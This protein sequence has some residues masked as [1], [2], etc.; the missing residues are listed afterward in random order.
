M[1]IALAPNGNGQASAAKD[2]SAISDEQPWLS[3]QLHSYDTYAHPHP[4]A[5]KALNDFTISPLKFDD[6]KSVLSSLTPGSFTYSNHVSLIDTVQGRQIYEVMQDIVVS[7]GDVHQPI[8]RL[9]VKRTDGLYCMIFQESNDKNMLGR[10]DPP[11]LMTIEG[12]PV[13]HIQDYFEGNT[14]GF[15]NENW[16][17]D[18][19]APYHLNF[20]DPG[21]KKLI[22]AGCTVIDDGEQFDLASLRDT[23]L[24]RS[25]TG[26]HPHSAGCGE[27]WVKYQI[28]KHRAVIVGDGYEPPKMGRPQGR[29]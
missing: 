27:V 29:H 22:P 13:L 3:Y 21:F 25:P 14:G 10:L 17:F 8:R 7:D 23:F 6:L 26:G 19:G 18:H 16:V 4:P 12:S 5:C 28:Q 24:V 11:N 1:S 2:Q 20:E 9:L 15:V